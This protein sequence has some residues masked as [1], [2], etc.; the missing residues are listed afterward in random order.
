MMNSLRKNPTGDT[1]EGISCDGDNDIAR[2]SHCH[3]FSLRVHNLVAVHKLL[4][5]ETEWLYLSHNIQ[6][7]IIIVLSHRKT[8]TETLLVLPIIYSSLA[9][10]RALILN[11]DIYIYIYI[12]RE[13]E[14]ESFDEILNFTVLVWLQIYIFIGLFIRPY[15]HSGEIYIQSWAKTW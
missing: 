14:R 12:E 2:C 5:T 6:L 8:Q 7:Q 9:N 4:I 15:I 11:S 1:I 13:R 10:R 3:T